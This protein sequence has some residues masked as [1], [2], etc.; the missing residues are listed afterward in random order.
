MIFEAKMTIVL[1]LST[2]SDFH[3]CPVRQEYG[4]RGF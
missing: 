4:E 2:A 3:S 1:E